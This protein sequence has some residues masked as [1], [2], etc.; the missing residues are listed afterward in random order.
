MSA[1]VFCL[2]KSCCIAAHVLAAENLQ[3]LAQDVISWVI[4]RIGASRS[5][6]L[7]E[8]M[9]ANH[10]EY[11]SDF[12]VLN[13]LMR[14]FLNVQ[15]VYEALD[16]V[17]RMRE[18]DVR[19]SLSAI[20]ILFRLLLRVGDYGSVWK[21]LR[22]MI[23][24]GPRPCNSNFNVMILSFCRKGY[25]RIGE[26]LLYVMQKFSCEPDVYTYNILISA[27]CM[28][29]RT[30]DALGL[31]HLMIK[32]GCKPSL[33]T[34]NTVINAFCKQGNVKEARKIFDEIQEV[35]VSPN[36]GMYNTLMNGY[37]KA[38]DVGQANILYEEMRNRGIAPDGT[39]FNI[40]FAGHCK[41]GR[42]EDSLRL[43]RDFSSR[44]GSRLFII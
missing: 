5:T 7:V 39:T 18:V 19:P 43:L 27:Y 17:G 40:L 32:N 21:L 30:S 34:F 8:F 33:I 25:A 23:R 3:L 1:K 41:Y 28:S 13:T 35:G 11:E 22:G 6:E 16:I 38:R 24:E 4:V 37:V 36:V 26:S 10:Y 15:M 31:V 42:E 29:G 9:W 14:G 2:V 44:F 20:T 12:S